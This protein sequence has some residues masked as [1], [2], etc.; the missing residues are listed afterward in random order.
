MATRQRQAAREVPMSCPRWASKRPLMLKQRDGA[1]TRSAYVLCSLRTFID[2]LQPWRRYDAV[3]A[4]RR[5]SI[6][7]ALSVILHALRISL[8]EYGARGWSPAWLKRWRDWA[9]KSR[10]S[11]TEVMD[12]MRSH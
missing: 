8:L 2:S 5:S 9:L 6:V 12:L 7:S 1:S 11:Y 4:S 10:G 3:L